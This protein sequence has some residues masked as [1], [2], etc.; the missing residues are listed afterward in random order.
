[1]RN[2]KNISLFWDLR[3][4]HWCYWRFKL[5]VMTFHV[6]WEIVTFQRIILPSS[7]LDPDNKALWSVSVTIYH[8]AL[9]NFNPSEGKAKYFFFN[10]LLPLWK[11][12]MPKLRVRVI[13]ENNYYFFLSIKKNLQFTFWVKYADA[14]QQY[15]QL[16]LP[17]VK[18][19]NSN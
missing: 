4:L 16:P 6:D 7:L 10:W 3:F 8:S 19:W 14:Y 17:Y 1:M 5:F 13:Y 9:V 15:T 12:T 11:H 2:A 18:H